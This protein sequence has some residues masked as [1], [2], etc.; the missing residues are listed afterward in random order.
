M[1]ATLADV[2]YRRRWIVLVTWI[3][4]VVG[5]TIASA[6]IGAEHSTTARLD[7]TDSQRAYDLLTERSRPR[8]ASRRASCSPMTPGWPTSGRRS[9]RSLRRWRR[10]TV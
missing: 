6:A 1:L 5:L 2:S 7:G 8:R 10:S 9:T 3:A 4:A